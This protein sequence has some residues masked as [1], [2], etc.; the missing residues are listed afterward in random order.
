MKQI[1]T[2]VEIQSSPDRIWQVL[3]DFAAFPDWNPFIKSVTGGL[4]PGSHLVIKIQPPKGMG[5]TFKPV[6]LAAEPGR[7]LRWRGKLL[8][9]GLFDG[10]HFFSIEDIGEGRARMVQGEKFT[11]L[12]VPVLAPTGIYRNTEAGFREMNKALKAQAESGP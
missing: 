11:G 12:L 4:E 10:E 8:M 3:T 6:V 2:E 7:E 9:P 5:M 1:R